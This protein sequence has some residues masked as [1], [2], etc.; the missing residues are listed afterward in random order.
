MNWKATIKSTRDALVCVVLLL[1]AGCATPLYETND[2]VSLYLVGEPVVEKDNYEI[3]FQF[4]TPTDDPHFIQWVEINGW[5]GVEA[6]R[7]RFN[8]RSGV[9]THFSRGIDRQSRLMTVAPG[10]V[11]GTDETTAGFSMLP[12]EW[13]AG[14]NAKYRERHTIQGRVAWRKADKAT[15]Y[16]LEFTPGCLVWS[17][18][19]TPVKREWRVRGQ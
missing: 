3:Q 11:E 8:Q 5:T 14:F 6:F 16:R 7:V 13:P 18:E 2:G 1:L 10:K 15:V 17:V 12:S 9:D 4:E 19:G